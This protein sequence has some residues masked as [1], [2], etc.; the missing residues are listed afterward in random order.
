MEFGGGQDPFLIL[1]LVSTWGWGG[2]AA[3]EGRTE[4]PSFD[5]CCRS[6]L[7]HA[8]R[9][10]AAPRFPPGRA[11]RARPAGGDV[12]DRGGSKLLV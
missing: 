12:G 5:G 2:R 3:R 8:C 7:E 9:G 10:H 11:W 6:G 4:R 1:F